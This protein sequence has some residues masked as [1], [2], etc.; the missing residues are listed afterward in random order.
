M[1]AGIPTIASPVGYQR[2]L[3]QEGVT[4]FLP[5]SDEAWEEALERLITNPE[6]VSVMGTASREVAISRFSYTATIPSWVQAIK[7]VPNG[8]P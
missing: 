7:N 3:V 6:L 2:E 1:A 5:G 4:G 8:S